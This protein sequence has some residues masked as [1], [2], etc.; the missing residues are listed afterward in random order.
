[1]CK[2]ERLEVGATNSSGAIQQF[3]KAQTA[4]QEMESYMLVW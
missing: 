2:Q 3:G 4:L 1:M